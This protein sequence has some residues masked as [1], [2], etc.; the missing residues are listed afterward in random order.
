MDH[1]ITNLQ[2]QSETN[3]T[4]HRAFSSIVEMDDNQFTIH[5]NFRTRVDQC[6]YVASANHRRETTE[7]EYGDYTKYIKLKN[8][9]IQK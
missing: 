9:N 8:N 3:N 1:N 7:Y 5:E 6:I 4:N 2:I